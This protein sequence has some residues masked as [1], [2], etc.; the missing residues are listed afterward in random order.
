MLV[1]D[2]HSC[3]SLF[4]KDMQLVMKLQPLISGVIMYKKFSQK[5]SIPVREFDPLY[6]EKNLPE[7]C[8]YGIRLLQI[9][10]DL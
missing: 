2:T 3:Q 9:R 6:A 5:T 8:G 10:D 1:N 4:N 7:N